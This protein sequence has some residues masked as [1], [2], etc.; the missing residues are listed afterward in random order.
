M[1]RRRAARMLH[2]SSASR[3]RPAARGARAADCRAAS[4]LSFGRPLWF[5]RPLS[6]G[7]SLSL[8][9]PLSL[10]MVL[11]VAAPFSLH[12]PTL[13]GNTRVEVQAVVLDGALFTERLGPADPS[14]VQDERVRSP[15]PALLWH[16]GAELLLDN[17][18][19]VRFG[20]PDAVGNAQH[21]T[22]DRQAGNAE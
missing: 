17:L 11:S 9:R 6:L 10:S 20:N 18:W 16:R 19:I 3:L 12:M 14:S 21:M 7:G 15:R 13:R 2:E 22:I 8:G 1:R 5:G 4:G